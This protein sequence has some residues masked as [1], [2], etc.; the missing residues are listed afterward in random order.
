MR[1]TIRIH[2]LLTN[3]V[4]DRE[5]TAE[6]FA[7]YNAVAKIGEPEAGAPIPQFPETPAE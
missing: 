2:D 6:E 1:P 7:I 3:E 5:M 4:V